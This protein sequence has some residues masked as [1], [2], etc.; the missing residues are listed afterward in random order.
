MKKITLSC[1]LITQILSTQNT[2]AENTIKTKNVIIS[3]NRF[4]STDLNAN[5]S[6]KVITRDEIEKSPYV[7]I[8]DLLRSQAGIN[9]VS[10]YGALGIDSIVDMRG[11]GQSAN[12]NTLILVD[13]QR[14]NEVDSATI[15]WSSI[16]LSRI[17]HIEILSGS[18]AVLYGD[19]ASGGVI[20][21]ITSKSDNNSKS[22]K[23][24]VGSYDFVGLDASLSGGDKGLYYN[25]SLNSSKDNGW[26]DNTKSIS[27]TISGRLGATEGKYDTFID[28]TFYQQENGLPGPL[29]SNAYNANPRQ[30]SQPNNFTRRDGYKFRPGLNIKINDSLEFS[31]EFL[32]SKHKNFSNLIDFASKSYRVTDTYALTP[33]IKW[34]HN[35]SDFKSSSVIGTDY[36]LGKLNVNNF[37]DKDQHAEDRSYAL[38]FQNTTYLTNELNLT[39]GFRSHYNKQEAY[40]NAYNDGSSHPAIDGKISRNKKAYEFSLNY[41]KDNW[42]GY[43]KTNQGFRFTNLDELYGFDSNSPYLSTFYGFIKPQTSKTNEVGLI[44]KANQVDARLALFKTSLTDEIAYSSSLFKNVNFDPTYRQGLEANLNFKVTEDID[45]RF[46]YSYLEAKFRSGSFVGKSI[47]MVPK[48]SGAMIFTWNKQN[49]SSYQL[50][51]NYVGSRYF[52]D[53]LEN[54]FQKLPN[55]ITVDGKASWRINQWEVNLRGLNIFDK[56]YVQYGILNMAKTD[57]AYFP[58]NGRTI[59]LSAQ[60]DF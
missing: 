39:S 51:A 55:T 15:Q 3:G 35:L 37:S 59:F 24:T 57:Q 19:K 34:D 29:L 46:N 56:N 6:I 31:G 33:R 2:F 49:Y 21:I 58:A 12:G 9:V 52:N 48:N 28:Y 14:L 20:N 25:T 60:Y 18:G 38:F 54:A 43:L 4:S 40:Q 53:D 23:T 7:S 5:Q 50:Q 16:P 42:G 36:Y 17:D 1:L 11:Y 10:T 44:Y 8:P 30:A 47:P 22:F 13:G 32:L 45:V 41:S 27:N 26:R